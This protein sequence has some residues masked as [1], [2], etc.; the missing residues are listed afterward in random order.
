MNAPNTSAIT[1]DPAV[2]VVIN[3]MCCIIAADGRV[4]GSEIDV[5][6]DALVSIGQKPSPE[7]FRQLVID[8][9]KQI[10]RMGVVAVA[11]SLSE[12]LVSLRN[13]PLADLI[14]QLQEDVIQSDNR[15]TDLEKA[16]AAR[17]RGALCPA[18]GVSS[19]D[20]AVADTELRE[21]PAFTSPAGTEITVTLTLLE[22]LFASIA[23]ARKFVD[24][25]VGSRALIVLCLGVVFGAISVLMSGRIEAAPAGAVLGFG[26]A[27][28]FLYV[29]P[30]ATIRQW[31]VDRPRARAQEAMLGAQAASITAA[32]QVPPLVGTERVV[33]PDI[34][35]AEDGSGDADGDEVGFDTAL[36]LVGHGSLSIPHRAKLARRVL[37]LL[38]GSRSR[39]PGKTACRCTDCG[40]R[41]W[42]AFVD[43]NG[44]GVICPYCGQYQR[45]TLDWKPAVPP[46]IA[47]VL[48]PRRWAWPSSVP[49]YSYGPVQVRGYVNKRGTWVAGH[50]RARPRRRR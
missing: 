13:K 29:V 25:N 21:V 42:F 49:S 44:R 1:C 3:C 20:S 32:L 14:L 8:T 10:H 40:R 11:E 24:N 30:D 37:S 16:V 47:P 35:D 4:S 22:H 43:T 34:D 31:A 2:S 6:F 7:V 45:A 19:L 18:S 5:V 27:S 26:L 9:C 12:R 23:P 50:T 33:L 17:F 38:R 41:Y 46:P 48:A 36:S 28:L 15:V 39:G